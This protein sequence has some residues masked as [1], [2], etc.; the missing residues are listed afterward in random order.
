MGS[1]PMVHAAQTVILLLLVFVAVFALVAR[2][3]NVSYPIVLVVA[4]LVVSFVPH[5]PRIP[6]NPDL[7]FLIF[8]P[9]LLFSSAWTMSWREFRANA[10]SIGMLAVGLVAFTV[11][12]VA[13]FS[14]RFVSALDWKSGFVL[15]AVVAAT[16]A[17][18]ATSIARSLGLPRR[19]VD[20]LE[21][22]SLLNDATALLALE[23][24]MRLLT[25]GA[26]PG[27]A[28]GLGRL[29]YLM[30]AGTGVG[31]AIGWLGAKLNEKIND[32]P[33][34]IVLSVVVPY[35]VYL[36]GEEVRASGVIAVVVCGLYVSRQSATIYS[37]EERLQ[38]YG[39]WNVL[40]FVLNGLVFV[41]I[42]LQLPFVM[43]D[44]HG[45]YPWM[46]LV[47]YGAGF[48]VV[49]IVLRLVWTYPALGLAHAIERRMGKKTGRPSRKG[50]FVIGWTGMRG[51]VSLAAAIALPETLPGGLTFPA[52][53]LVVFLAFCVIL[54]SLVVQGLSLPPLIRWLGLS[55]PARVDEEEREARRIVLGE[56]M[57]FLEQGREQHGQ[58]LDHAYDDL[59]HRYRHRLAA[60]GGCDEEDCVEESTFERARLIAVEALGVERRAMIRLREDDRINDDVL[61]KLQKEVD[62]QDSQYGVPAGE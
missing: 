41:L 54:V 11:W 59:L 58:E 31:L 30:V 62:L 8:L 46:T 47:K 16:D 29:L 60:A 49:L 14:D 13:E 4:G 44:I 6:L 32:G 35:L 18:A 61:R 38:L 50:I 27:V 20:I 3:L 33:V 39:V 10:V 48:S 37:A 23:F 7:V 12:G 34:A 40:T 22:E 5:V 36:A 55:Q 56:A 9:P 51:V 28:A 1:G 57:A 52:R 53:N 42:G 19:I 24:G 25:Q 21:G 45:A 43:Q 17:I 26:T 2:W 15:G